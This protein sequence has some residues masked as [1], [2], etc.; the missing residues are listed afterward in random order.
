MAFTGQWE[1]M[2]SY[3]TGGTLRHTPG[4]METGAHS[5]LIGVDHGS[6]VLDTATILSAK[7]EGGY[8]RIRLTNGKEHLV[9]WNLGRLESAL[10]G[11]GFFRCHDSWVINLRVVVRLHNGDGHQ[12][13][14]SDGTKVRVS[15]RR[16]SEFVALLRGGEGGVENRDDRTWRPSPD[17]PQQLIGR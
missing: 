8:S 15:R 11:A 12:A 1:R 9:C 4:A 13:E 14:L 3:D 16:Y 7:A 10:A 2:H 5:L 17:L 6:L